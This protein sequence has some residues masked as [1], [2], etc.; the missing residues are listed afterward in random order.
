[1]NK[2]LEKYHGL[3]LVKIIRSSK[4]SISFIKEGANSYIVNQTAGIYIKYS[5]KRLSPWPFTFQKKHQDEIALLHKRYNKV[6]ICFI[7]HNDGVVC[8]SFDELKFILDHNHNE[9]EWIKISRRPGTKYSVHG[10]D[11]KLKNKKGNSEFPKIILDA[12]KI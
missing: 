11:G 8:L 12:L 9:N 2:D 7:C 3:T 1:M 6:F 5:T 10:S 4:A